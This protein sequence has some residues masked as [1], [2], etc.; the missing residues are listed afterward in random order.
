MKIKEKLL[1]FKDIDIWSL[2]LFTL[3][4]IKDTPEFS[5]ISE[6]AYVL[7]KDS[8]LKLCE[9]FGGLTIKIPTI[10]ELEDLVYALVIYQHVNIDGMNYNDA[11]KLIGEKSSNLRNIKFNYMKICDILDK[12]EFEKR[13]S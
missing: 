7:D 10:E 11:I 2:I 13:G 6:L 9:Y 1:T 12:Y 4:K 5:T 3:Y 8:M